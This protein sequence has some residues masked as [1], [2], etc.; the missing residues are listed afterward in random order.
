MQINL[1]CDAK[2]KKFLG[3][4]LKDILQK[5]RTHEIDPYSNKLD[6]LYERLNS[7]DEFLGLSI[8]Y[9]TCELYKH[10]ELLW[11]IN[12]TI[13]NYF[14]TNTDIQIFEVPTNFELVGREAFRDCRDLIS[15]SITHNLE[16]IQ[17]GAFKNCVNLKKIIYKGTREEFDRLVIEDDNEA[18][19]KAEVQCLL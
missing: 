6:R 7:N 11:C 1:N 9:L 2:T 4:Q 17:Q 8:S 3:N 19:K 16:R 13:P 10:Y 5:Y 14:L 12:S 15:I 18:F